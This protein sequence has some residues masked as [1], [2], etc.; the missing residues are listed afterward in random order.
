MASVTVCCDFWNPRKENLLLLPLFPLLFAMKLC[1]YMPIHEKYHRAYQLE[2]IPWKLEADLRQ[3]VHRRSNGGVSSSRYLTK[4]PSLF[5]PWLQILVMLTICPHGPRLMIIALIIMCAQS[6]RPVRLFVTLWTVACQTPLSMAFSR[7]QDWS[8][9][10]FPTPRDVPNSGPEP[11][12]TDS[13]VLAS[14]F[15]TTSATW[16]AGINNNKN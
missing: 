4:D 10:P 6:L 14:R 8:G 5:F 11:T 3:D 7:Q 1:D 2:C 15:F 9:L 12:S 16:E 13:P